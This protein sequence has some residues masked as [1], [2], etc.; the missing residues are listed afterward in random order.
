MRE[1]RPHL[2]TESAFVQ[3]VTQQ[4][5]QGYMLAYVECEAT[6]RSVAGFRITQNLSWGRHLFVDDLVTRE[7]DCGSGFGG[8]LFDWLVFEAKRSGCRSVH[9]D[10]GVQRFGAH[11][12]YLAKRMDIIAHHFSLALD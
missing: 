7:T 11:R 8:Q 10:S 6:V 9:L 5:A 2:G 4:G 12:F 3:A 1:L